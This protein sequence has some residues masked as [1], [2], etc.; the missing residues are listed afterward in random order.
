MDEANEI[1]QEEVKSNDL[2]NQNRFN[3]NLV[4]DRDLWQKE[5]PVNDTL[6]VAFSRDVPIQL[7]ETLLQNF[8]PDLLFLQSST[9]DENILN[10]IRKMSTNNRSYIYHGLAEQAG[11]YYDTA[12]LELLAMID[13]SD[14]TMSHSQV[15]SVLLRRRYTEQEKK[16]DRLLDYSFIAM[17]YYVPSVCSTDSTE[18]VDDFWKSVSQIQRK[19]RPT[20]TSLFPI[21]LAIHEDT[22]IGTKVHE[23]PETWL[24]CKSETENQEKGVSD[25]YLCYYGSNTYSKMLMGGL[26]HIDHHLKQNYTKKQWKNYKTLCNQP[27]VDPIRTANRQFGMAFIGFRF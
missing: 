15:Y 17:S 22:G 23:L 9:K 8:Y 5:N 20:R 1:K 16:C 13:T 7:V 11:L 6:V 4:R 12:K 24:C 10:E 27:P 3:L 21:V 2:E 14:F 19:I 26:R 18:G 25:T